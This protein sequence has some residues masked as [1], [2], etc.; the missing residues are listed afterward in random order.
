MSLHKTLLLS[1]SL[2]GFHN[3]GFI[4]H[5]SYD[6]TTEND[7]IAMKC[8]NRGEC[9]KGMHQKYLLLKVAS[10]AMLHRSSQQCHSCN[11]HHPPRAGLIRKSTEYHSLVESHDIMYA[12]QQRH[13]ITTLNTNKISNMLHQYNRCKQLDHVL[14]VYSTLLVC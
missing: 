11:I 13:Y 8:L 10:V 12:Y 14:T 1:L 3:P 2:S 5:A 6:N 4:H 7:N 9:T